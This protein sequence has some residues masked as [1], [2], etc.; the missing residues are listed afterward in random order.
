MY[1]MHFV[2]AKVA[3]K[4]P[5]YSVLFILSLDAYFGREFGPL[6]SHRKIQMVYKYIN[7]CNTLFKDI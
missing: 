1:I 5:S 6:W 7:T 3:A 4:M 2:S